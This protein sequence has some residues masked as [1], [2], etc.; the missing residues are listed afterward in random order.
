MNFE[1]LIDI[2]WYDSVRD[3]SADY[4]FEPHVDF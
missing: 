2:F 4:F 3:I 1:A